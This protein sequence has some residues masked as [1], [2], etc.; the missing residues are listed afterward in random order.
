MRASLKKNER[1]INCSN[2]TCGTSCT[3]FTD[4]LFDLASTF[5][6]GQVFS[7]GNLTVY[8]KRLMISEQLQTDVGCIFTVVDLMCTLKLKLKRKRLHFV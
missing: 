6:V 7:L 5:K 4:M 8:L 2:Y 1:G 3:V